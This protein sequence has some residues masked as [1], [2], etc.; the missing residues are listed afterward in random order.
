MKVIEYVAVGIAYSLTFVA[1]GVALGYTWGRPIEA[2]IWVWGIVTAML[3][4][5]VVL[6]ITFG[7]P[8]PLYQR[9]K[10]SAPAIGAVVAASALAWSFFYQA[11][12]NDLKD[13]L[14]K[15]RQS[16]EKLENKMN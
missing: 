2:G 8:D 6:V 14:N 15:L 7:W 11:S 16:I 1:G 9:I 13:D 3:G 10:D 12:A 4:I 5:S